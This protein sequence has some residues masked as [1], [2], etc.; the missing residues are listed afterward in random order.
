MTFFQDP[1][2]DTE[3][4]L[5]HWTIGGLTL[6]DFGHPELFRLRQFGQIISATTV[7]ANYF[8]YD[9][10]GKL[11][12]LRQFGQIISAKAVSDLKM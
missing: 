4:G 10:S 8:G 6:P 2:V 3:S 1:F 11:F 7:P 12:R 5:I 9:S